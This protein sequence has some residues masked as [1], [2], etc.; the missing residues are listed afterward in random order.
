MSVAARTERVKATSAVV[1]HSQ[2]A[3]CTQMSTVFTLLELIQIMFYYGSQNGSWALF[4]VCLP[5][6]LYFAR[7]F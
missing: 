5:S 7:V 3:E 2:A 1:F 4:F 6:P